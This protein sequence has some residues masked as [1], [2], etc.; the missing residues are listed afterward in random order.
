MAAARDLDLEQVGQ[1]VDHRHADAV[2]AAGGLVDLGIEFAAGMQ[3][4][5]D[6]FERRLVLELG[7][8]VDRD[9]AAVVGD[10]QEALGVEFDLDEGGMAGNGLVHRV[11]DDFGE[12]MV[13]RLFVG[14]ADIHARTA[15]NRLQTFENLDVG[16]AI[17]F[18]AVLGR[19]RALCHRRCL[20]QR[21]RRAGD[22]PGGL[23]VEISEK[24]VA[25]VHGRARFPVCE[26]LVIVPCIGGE[27]D[28]GSPFVQMQ[29]R[30]RTA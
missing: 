19:R 26:S 9:A 29:K 28:M 17:A 25:I 2:Q 16:G 15:A 27:R 7:V 18:A 3:R 14:A 12:Q 4:R 1:R 24:I 13:Q 11:V 5:H 23:L 22:R 20:H 21:I 8:R 10:G 6:D 30:R